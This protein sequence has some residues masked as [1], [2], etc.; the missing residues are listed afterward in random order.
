MSLSKLTLFASLASALI[1]F[2]DQRPLSSP[3]STFQ[4]ELPPV[5]DPAGDGLP[6]ASDLFSSKDALNKQVERHQA[7]V[8]V[9]SICF[10]DLGDFDSDKRWKPFNKLHDVLAKT[11]PLV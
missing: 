7:I 6:S 5:L 10:D 1:A 9:P 8:R 4:C 11:Y 2:P 3:S